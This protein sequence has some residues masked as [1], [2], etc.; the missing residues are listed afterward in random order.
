[1]AEA[2]DLEIACH[3]LDIRLHFDIA[4]SFTVYVVIRAVL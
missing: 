1:M 2:C 4:P 3:I